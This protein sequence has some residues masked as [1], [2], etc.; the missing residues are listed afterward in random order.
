[1]SKEQQLRAMREARYAGRSAASGTPANRLKLVKPG[2]E[3]PVAP[4][5]EQTSPDQLCGHKSMNGRTC[6]REQGHTA[7]S[8]RYS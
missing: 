7:K 4:P 3:L 5:V 6:T 2:A 1:M 8:H